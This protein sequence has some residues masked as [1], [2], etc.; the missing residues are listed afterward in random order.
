MSVTYLVPHDIF[1]HFIFFLFEGIPWCSGDSRG[2]APAYGQCRQLHVDIEPAHGHHGVAVS[3]WKHG[4]TILDGLT[5]KSY[6][7][8]IGKYNK[9]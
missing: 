8:R 3:V 2:R 6:K 1:M 4:Q 7:R 9:R 5:R